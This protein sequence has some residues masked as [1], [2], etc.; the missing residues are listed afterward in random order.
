V[1][2]RPEQTASALRRAVQEVLG[3][4]L[5][6]PRVRGIITVTGLDLSED[7]REAVVKVSVMPAEHQELTVHGLR[8]ASGHIRRQ[9][10]DRIR[11]RRMP[12][13]IFRLDTSLKKQAEVLGALARAREEFGEPDITAAPGGTAPADP[14]DAAPHDR[15]TPPRPPADRDGAPEDAR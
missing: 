6:D 1:S 14:S 12:K 13:L 10:A 8:A 9:A 5:Q 3:R 2:P 4:G 7:G 15:H 11:I